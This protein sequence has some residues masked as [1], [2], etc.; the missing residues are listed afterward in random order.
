MKMFGIAGWSGCGKTT[1]VRRLI[2]L[3]VGQG[4]SVACVKHSHHD[5]RPGDD[6]AAA[7]LAAGAA[8]ALVGGTQRF[9]LFHEHHAIPE[10][11]LADLARRFSDVDLLLVE[12]FK[13]SAHPKL[14]VWDPSLGKPLLAATD[15]SIV[16]IACDGPVPPCGR[17]VLSRDDG[18]GL[19]RYV[20]DKSV[21][22]D[23]MNSKD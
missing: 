14:E 19:C 7:L 8:E 3:L 1:L 13:F 20:T 2:P 17:P 11:S 15:P 5:I 4:L 9:A 22:I 21:T 12:G 23:D 16:A 6:E 10:P 18:A